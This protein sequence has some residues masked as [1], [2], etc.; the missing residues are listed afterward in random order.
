MNESQACLLNSPDYTGSVKYLKKEI[1]LW[2][3]AQLSCSI[4]CIFW[5]ASSL[6]IYMV[7]FSQAR[8]LEM[9]KK[10]QHKKSK[11]PYF[12]PF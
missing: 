6:L 5:L 8:K 1:G 9:V 3:N 4:Y 2:M 12:F 10:T 11:I 7:I